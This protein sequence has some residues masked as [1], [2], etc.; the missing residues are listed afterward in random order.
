[1]A[2]ASGA[3]SLTADT[4]IA[5]GKA[6]AGHI[7]EAAEAD[8]EYADGEFRVASTNWLAVGRLSAVASAQAPPICRGG[9]CP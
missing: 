4:V 2:L 6:L 9:V 3:I 8:I 7:L 5:K 1:M